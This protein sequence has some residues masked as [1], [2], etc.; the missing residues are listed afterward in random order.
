MTHKKKE[1]MHYIYFGTSCKDSSLHSEQYFLSFLKQ[2]EFIELLSSI[3]CHVVTSRHLINF[4]LD[5][6]NGPTETTLV[7]ILTS[8]IKT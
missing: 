6:P 2:Y 5:S 3:L 1:E 4:S 7:F 8:E